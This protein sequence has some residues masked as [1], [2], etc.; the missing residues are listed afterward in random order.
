MSNRKPKKNASRPDA[1]DRYY[2]PYTADELAE[3]R[4]QR[5][6]PNAVNVLNARLWMCVHFAECACEAIRA[7]DHYRAYSISELTA[8]FPRQMPTYYNK[9]AHCNSEISRRATGSDGSA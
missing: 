6:F 7:G 1:A 3:S 5:K 4:G 9:W 2:V 8:P